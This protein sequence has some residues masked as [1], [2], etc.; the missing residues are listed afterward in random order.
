MRVKPF[1]SWARERSL[2]SMWVNPP[3]GIVGPVELLARSLVP[4]PSWVV[5]MTP[6]AARLTHP[7]LRGFASRP[8]GRFAFSTLVLA[9][10]VS[11]RA[12]RD[13]TP[14]E[15]RF[16]HAASI[17]R[18]LG[19]RLLVLFAVLLGLTALATSL[20]PRRRRAGRASCADALPHRDAGAGALRGRLG[21]DREDDL[22]RPGSPACADP[23]PRRRHPRADRQRR[24]ARR[25]RDRGAREARADRAR[26]P[27][28]LR[29]AA[30]APG[31][32][33]RLTRRRG[34][35][36]RPVEVAG[37]AL[38]GAGPARSSGR[39]ASWPRSARGSTAG[40]GSGA[41]RRSCSPS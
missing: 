11:A 34:A 31:R 15:A 32:A 21:A 10:S 23:R 5:L 6:V 33:P 16:V 1:S 30:G 41:G 39:R 12:T 14:A 19:R 9:R 22:G 40:C 18:V 17:G 7:E 13:L 27:R 8:R 24:R 20:A 3:E 36:G 28:A 29:G 2:L 4:L 26:L 37:P 38:S 35:P 25:R